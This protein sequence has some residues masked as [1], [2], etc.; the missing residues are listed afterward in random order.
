MCISSYF[1]VCLCLLSLFWLFNVLKFYKFLTDRNICFYMNLKFHVF[2][3]FLLNFSI[4]WYFIFV[5]IVILIIPSQ[6]FH[7]RART[8]FTLVPYRILIHTK[9]TLKHWNG[10][11]IPIMS[12]VYFVDTKKNIVGAHQYIICL[13]LSISLASSWFRFSNMKREFME[14][15]WKRKNIVVTVFNPFKQR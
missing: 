6:C 1:C 12:I 13:S 7:L 14:E 5:S 2:L 8:F 10:L 11:I 3:L 15:E 4:R 9:K